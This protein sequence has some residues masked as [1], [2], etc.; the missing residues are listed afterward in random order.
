MN[1]KIE[2]ILEDASQIG[3]DELQELF[4]KKEYSKIED[5]LTDKDLYELINST[6]Q[7]IKELETEM[8]KLK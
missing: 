4:I 7:E 1:K 8:S 6:K 2:K 3:D 5:E